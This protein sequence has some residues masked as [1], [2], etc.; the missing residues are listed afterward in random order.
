MEEVEGEFC[1]K[2]Q[3][4]VFPPSAKGRSPADR[5]HFVF[6]WLAVNK[7]YLPVKSVVF[8]PHYSSVLPEEEGVAR[9]FKEVSPEVWLP[10]GYELVPYSRMALLKGEQVWLNREEFTLK[11]VSLVPSYGVEFFRDIDFPPG[12]VV[13]EFGPGQKLLRNYVV[14]GVASWQRGT[15]DGTHR[16]WVY[17]LA[18]V[19]MMLIVAGGMVIRRRANRMSSGSA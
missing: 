19:G 8:T 15:R 17:W 1:V 13:Y 6:L 11:S 4:D 5:S 7:N 12:T 10:H 18:G 14:G 9:N 2:L 16:W 3:Y